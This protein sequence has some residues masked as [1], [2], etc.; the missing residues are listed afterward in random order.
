MPRRPIS[1]WSELAPEQRAGWKVAGAAFLG[2]RVVVLLAALAGIAVF[3]YSD[4]F[5]AGINPYSGAAKAL[6][7]P[8]A[9]WDAGQ[10]LGIALQ[11]YDAEP[12]RMVFF[13]LYP[14][15]IHLVGTAIGS[16]YLAAFLISCTAFFVALYV[17]Y[18]LTELELDR[19][20]ARRTVV[21]MAFC[22]MAFF[23]SAIY[24]ESLFLALSLG[25]VYSA[26]LGRWPAAGG[27]GALAACT[28]NTGV[29]LLVPLLLLLLYGPRADRQ[30]YVRRG[31]KSG[32]NP[33]YGL[34]GEAFWLL[35]VPAGL[36]AYLAYS[37]IT[38]G[39]PRTPMGGQAEFGR[40][41]AG[42]L[43]AVVDAVRGADA[44]ARD[45]L[46][47]ESLLGATGGDAF[48]RNR[49]LELATFVA[50]AAAVIGTLRLLPLAYGAYALTG[51]IFAISAPNE[52]DA[53][54]SLPRFTLALFPLFMWLGHW[55]HTRARTILVG[56]S[57]ALL[58]PAATAL[59]AT[60]HF[61][62]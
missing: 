60:W 10:Y 19:A 1:W 4:R 40:H 52:E 22:P 3:G 29:L 17:L 23:F 18:R 12:S 24:T 47:G 42:P 25:S 38:T 35:L 32:R 26:R 33:R 21:L 55:T 11:G 14:L 41:F 51:L 30:H 49:P 50:A 37:T 54:L 44:S 62:A 57:W 39:D 9:V 36:V 16:V 31:A 7:S 43:A 13:P 20:S 45:I 6:F 48:V 61:V 5:S 15:L 28:R 27:F 59:F 34:G 2:S 53:F 56:A 8:V 58:L 46:A